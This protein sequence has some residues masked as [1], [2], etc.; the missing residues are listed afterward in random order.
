MKCG[1]SPQIAWP[2]TP[3]KRDE[4]KWAGKD[5]W[6]S[7]ELHS[8]PHRASFKPVQLPRSF[9]KTGLLMANECLTAS[10]LVGA[11]VAADVARKFLVASE[12]FTERKLARKN[13][14]C[15]PPSPTDPP[16][17]PLPRHL[18]TNTLDDRCLVAATCTLRHYLRGYSPLRGACLCVRVCAFFSPPSRRY[19]WRGV[20]SRVLNVLRVI[21]PSWID[22]DPISI[23]RPG[24]SGA[25]W[26]RGFV[27]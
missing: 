1:F 22:V 24:D 3:S 4:C 18:E 25:R 17:L 26:R 13:D 27:S 19:L 5:F 2:A 11:R 14:K 7:P 10:P 21:V 8:H 12:E 16:P 9:V 6:V 15:A 20:S 23:S